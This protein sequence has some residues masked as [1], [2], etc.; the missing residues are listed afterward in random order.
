[1]FQRRG[2]LCQVVMVYIQMSPQSHMQFQ[3]GILEDDSMMGTLYPEMSLQENVF[4]GEV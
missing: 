3:V 4:G 1:M 2:G